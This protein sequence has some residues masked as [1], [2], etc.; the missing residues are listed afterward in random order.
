MTIQ[1]AAGATLRISAALPATFDAAG[2]ALIF[3]A[4]PVAANPRVGEITDLGEFGREFALITHNPIG[5]RATQKFKGSFNEGTMSLTLALNTA[6]AGQTLMNTASLSNNAHAFE[7][8]L[9]NGARYYFLAQVMSWKIGVGSVDQLVSATVQLEIT[10][11]DGGVGV[12]PVPA[13]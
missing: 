2:Y 3:P 9:Q 1:S 5:T 13:V 12:V 6:D 10:S 7:V 8:R 4:L 11:S